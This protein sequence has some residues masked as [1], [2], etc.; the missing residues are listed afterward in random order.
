MQVMHRTVLALAYNVCVARLS[1]TLWEPR[2]ASPTIVYFDLHC[3]LSCLLSASDSVLSQDT[4]RIVIMQHSDRLR[5]S[6]L[7]R[8]CTVLT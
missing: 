5:S 2:N 6:I 3:N 1:N 4:W 7:C 8:L